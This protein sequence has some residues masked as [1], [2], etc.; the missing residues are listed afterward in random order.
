MSG[1][2]LDRMQNIYTD[3]TSQISSSVQNIKLKQGQ[4]FSIPS[5]NVPANDSASLPNYSVGS[6][7]FSY[8]E[9]NSLYNL[10]HV[11]QEPSEKNGLHNQAQNQQQVADDESTKAKIKDNEDSNALEAPH[12]ID[13]LKNSNPQIDAA[14][15]AKLYR[16][17]DL[18]SASNIMMSSGGQ[19]FSLNDAKYANDTY[20]FNFNINKTP[21]IRL[22]FMHKFNRSFDYKV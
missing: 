6:F 11:L 3:L 5:A 12:F 4:G 10:H 18:S 20:N 1:L 17:N 8:L 19:N 21:E 16:Q 13:E 2:S 9:P 15:I 14:S 22:E 7:A